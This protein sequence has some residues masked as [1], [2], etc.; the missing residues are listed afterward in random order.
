MRRRKGDFIVDRELYDKVDPSEPNS[1]HA[2]MLKFCGENRR[3]I[4]FGCWKG[5]VSS[6]LKKKGCYVLGIEMD[7]DAA[8]TARGICD[9]V[10]VADLDTLDLTE[11][12]GG[13]KYD[14]GLFGDVIEHLRDPKRILVQMREALSPGGFV[15]ASVPNVAHATV[16]LKLLKGD[17]DY[18]DVG[19]LDDTHLK[20]Y[21]RKTITS[22]IETCGFLVESVDWTELRIPEKEI[23]ETL[24]PLQLGNLEEVLKAL[25]SWEAIAFQY[26]L[27]AFP[28]QEWEQIQ[29]LSEEKVQAEKRAAWLDVENTGLRAVA[30][31]VNELQESVG[32]YSR[33]IIEVTGYTRTLEKTIKEKDDYIAELEQRLNESA[34][35]YPDGNTSILELERRLQAVEISLEKMRKAR[36]RGK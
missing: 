4:D 19:I 23:R 8:E 32:R 36:T 35:T 1:S 30:D 31:L 22:L 12:L 20:Y 16:R 5:A 26:I 28:A 14:I 10:I 13:T 18:M 3:V 25:S 34:G 6:E 24:D 2:K 11:A 9:R 7:P 33:E 21:T 27:K 15:V 17:F 29:R